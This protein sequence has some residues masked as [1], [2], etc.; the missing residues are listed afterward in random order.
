MS[1]AEQIS[2]FCCNY[3]TKEIYVL[4]FGNIY[5][6][7]TVVETFNNSLKIKAVKVIVMI[8]MNEF[9]NKRTPRSMITD[10][11]NIM[12]KLQYYHN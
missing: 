1:A 9:W 6:L 4:E 11:Y 12:P 8:S 7:F 3:L 5:Y 2:L 10:P